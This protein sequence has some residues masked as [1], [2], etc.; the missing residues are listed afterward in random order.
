MGIDATRLGGRKGGNQE[1]LIAISVDIKQMVDEKW[2]RI[3]GTW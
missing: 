3:P 2:R 1:W